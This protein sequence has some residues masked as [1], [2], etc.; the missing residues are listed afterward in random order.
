MKIL[1]IEFYPNLNCG[2]L[3][4]WQKMSQTRKKDIR[5]Y[6]SLSACLKSSLV[7]FFT[8]YFRVFWSFPCVYFSPNSCRTRFYSGCQTTSHIQ[9]SSR[10]ITGA[11]FLLTLFSNLKDVAWIGGNFSV[12][13]RLRKNMYT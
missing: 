11:L 12:Q 7:N 6:F 13:I 3:K 9:V 8:F 4:I 2:V 1:H 10:N 5:P